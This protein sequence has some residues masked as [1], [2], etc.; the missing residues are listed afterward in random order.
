MEKK[1]TIIP[2]APG[3]YIA[4]VWYEANRNKIHLDAVIA[5]RL[6]EYSNGGIRTE[7]IDPDGKVEFNPLEVT[8]GAV[9]GELYFDSNLDTY[10]DVHGQIYEGIDG[11]LAACESILE[12]G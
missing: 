1:T 9:C 3:R 8:N 12:D 5:Y 4:T 11:V 7:F 10:T 2:A 6:T